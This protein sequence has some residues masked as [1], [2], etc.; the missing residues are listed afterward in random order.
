M[1]TDTRT[2]AVSVSIIPVTT[3]AAAQPSPLHLQPSTVPVRQI[4]AQ[5]SMPT[6][7]VS[8][9]V[10]VDPQATRK[11]S[12]SMYRGLMFM[13]K[14]RRFQFY[15]RRGDCDLRPPGLIGTPTQ[16]SDSARLA[17]EGVNQHSRHRSIQKPTLFYNDLSG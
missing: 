6:K 13:A 7:T 12:Q 15:L 14:S 5:S 3:A 11:K 10:A 4:A 16:S 1:A 17:W 8:S 2:K 9:N